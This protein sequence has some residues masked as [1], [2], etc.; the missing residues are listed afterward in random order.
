MKSVRKKAKTL[1][2]QDINEILPKNEQFAVI[3]NELPQFFRSSLEESKSIAFL[4]RF[5]TKYVLKLDTAAEFLRN[6]TNDYSL[7]EINGKV[8]Q[9]YESVYFDSPNLHC[10]NMHHNKRAG[11]F[12]FRTRHYLSNG[13]IFNEIKQK[14]N[15]GK[16]TKIR[17]RR[18][19]EI[20][21]IPVLNKLSDFDENFK[22][23]IKNNGYTLEN[24][25]PV[26]SVYF[27]RITL[28]NK[29]FPERLTLDFGLK[30]G[31]SGAEIYL[32]DTAIAEIKRD[33]SFTQTAAQKFFRSI[34]KMPSGFSKYCIGICLTHKN[35]KINRFMPKIRDVNF[36]TNNY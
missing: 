27:N 3:E 9:N 23:L 12:K 18:D 15:T 22:N 20:N 32:N 4:N 28:L 13:M 10:F 34:K 25:E 7:L 6:V 14:L 21:G 36:E 8:V 11:R 19:E 30:Y 16:T 1:Q 2:K 17:Q 24:L 31:F 35:V 5:D 33:R 29:N 26:L